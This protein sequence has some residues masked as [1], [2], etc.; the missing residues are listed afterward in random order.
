MNFDNFLNN[1]ICFDK[2]QEKIILDNSKNCLVIAGAG[3]GKTTVITAKVKYL[4]EILHINPNDILVI[5]FTNESVNDLKKEINDKLLLKVSIKTFHKLALEII[6]NKQYRILD[7][8]KNILNVYFSR[9]IYFTNYYLF[10]L[11]YY[12]VY[13]CNQSLN[14]IKI[15][16]IYIS[17]LEEVAIFNFLNLA[18]LKFKYT[19]INFNN[20]ISTFSFDFNNKKVVVRFLNKKKKKI[21][22]KNI[23]Y[24]DLLKDSNILSELYISLNKIGTAS[25]ISFKVDDDNFNKFIELCYSFI[26][27]YKVN[28]IDKDYFKILINN[29]KNNHRLILFLTL[30]YNFYNYY[31]NY[32]LENNIIDFNDMI[33]KSINI[34]KQNNHLG[35]KYIII[36]EF[37]DISKNRLEIIKLLMRENVSVLAFGDDWQA[38]F[39]F[40]GSDIDLFTKFPSIASNCNV[41]KISRTYRNSQELINVAGNFIMKNSNQIKK[42]LVSSKSIK[43]SIVIHFYDENEKKSKL[44]Y[45]IILTILKERENSKI[46]LIGRYKFDVKEIIDNEYFK[47]KNEKIICLKKNVDITFLTSHASKGMTYD[48]VIILNLYDGIYGFPSKVIDSR[49]ISILKSKENYYYAEER[50]LFYVALTR[51]R[52][53][54]YL[55]VPILKPSIFVLELL[56]Y[57]NVLTINLT[58]KK[59]ISNNFFCDKCGYKLRKIINK[60]YICS[61]CENIFYI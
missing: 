36:D 41:L 4:V 20:V 49:E 6:G 27:N 33:N 61:N 47:I 5:S 42:N 43:N 24:I 17:C 60:K 7:N 34:L 40:A 28:F 56:N 37:Q 32:N 50:R 48:D 13:I 11:E 3:S 38:I 2:E 51:T 59:I 30:I 31:T 26:S 22:R 8:L 19:L 10:F 44:I 35:Y 25:F 12:Y 9:D 14:K 16:N 15:N 55:V 1:D 23:Y 45:N 57:D 53:K 54:N 46:L 52:N 18:K 58:D 21:K 39:G 29:Y